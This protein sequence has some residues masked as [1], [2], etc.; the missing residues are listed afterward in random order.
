M[1]LFRTWY[2]IHYTYYSAHTCIHSPLSRHNH[3]CAGTV[4]YSLYV[5]LLTQIH[6]RLANTRTRTDTIRTHNVRSRTYIWTATLQRRTVTGIRSYIRGNSVIDTRG[7]THIKNWHLHTNEQRARK[8]RYF[9]KLILRLRILLN[10][11]TV[12]TMAYWHKRK[13]LYGLHIYTNWPR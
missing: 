7:V 1:Q 11:L 3:W 4:S 10:Y 9:L 2:G 13:I 6:I 5:K 12:N 8:L